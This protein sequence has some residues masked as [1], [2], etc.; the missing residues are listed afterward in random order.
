MLSKT[1]LLTLSFT[2]LYIQAT[3]AQAT[4]VPECAL[5]CVETAANT[6]GCQIGDNICLCNST[7]FIPDAISCAPSSGCSSDDVAR[8]SRILGEM[9]EASNVTSSTPGTSTG[10]FSGTRSGSLPSG[11][12]LPSTGSGTTVTVTPSLSLSTLSLSR[13]VTV[14]ISVPSGSGT[15]TAVS[16][17]AP[18]SLPT[19]ASSASLSRTI[20][21]A[22]TT[23]TSSTTPFNGVST[24]PPSS[25]TS[26]AAVHAMPG[27]NVGMLALVGVPMILG[28]GF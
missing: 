20:P 9:C 4:S 26:N 7:E 25:Q 1:F 17:S 6:A 11:I 27:S 2:Y 15:R 3:W 13:S 12:S 23:L 5:Q 28:V 21:S 14:P 16:T 19:G 10:T 18:V 8:A 22:T 24:A